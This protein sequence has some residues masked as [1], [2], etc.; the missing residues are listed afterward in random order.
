MME[1]RIENMRGSLR[2]LLKRSMVRKERDVTCNVPR[3]SPMYCGPYSSNYLNKSLGIVDKSQ[4]KKVIRFYEWSDLTRCPLSFDDLDTFLRFLA[5]SG[6]YVLPHDVIRLESMDVIYG[7]CKFGSKQFIF[8]S[9][10]D[11]LQF[12]LTIEAS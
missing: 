12:A 3:T 6:V 9:S 1:C 2:E 5:V 4:S 7:I 10:K 8:A 11:N